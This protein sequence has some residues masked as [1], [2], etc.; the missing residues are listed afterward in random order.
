MYRSYLVFIVFP[1]PRPN[2]PHEIKIYCEKI[3]VRAK[4]AQ[5][6]EKKKEKKSRNEADQST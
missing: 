3:G 5:Q 1:F 6:V 2:N 4:M